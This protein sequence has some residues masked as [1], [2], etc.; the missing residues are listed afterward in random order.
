VAAAVSVANSCPYCVEV[1]AATLGGLGADAGAFAD[2]VLHEVPDPGL[3]ALAAWAGGSA[4]FPGGPVAELVGVAV[5]FHYLNR[6]VSVF[7]GESPLPAALPSGARAVAGRVLGRVMRRTAE[8]VLPSGD[9]LSL[10]PAAPAAPDLGW[11]SGNAT[12]AGAFARAVATVDATASVPDAVRGLV[13]GRLAGW[14]GGPPPLSRAWVADAVRPL[15]PAEQAAGRLALLVA[16]AAYQVDPAVIDGFR[17]HQ[18]SDA[19]LVELCSWAALSAARAAGGLL[20][21]RTGEAAA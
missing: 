7:L 10:L 4:P 16:F 13:A 12:I 2:G 17:R 21:R 9:S 8:P 20:W 1:H 3:R 11:T 15:A 18:P 5:A 14:D 6:M 19:A